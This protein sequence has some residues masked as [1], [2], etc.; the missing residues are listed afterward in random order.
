LQTQGK[1][2]DECFPGTV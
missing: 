2:V 1:A